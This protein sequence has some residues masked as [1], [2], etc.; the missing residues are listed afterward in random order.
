MAR[1]R[2][3]LF[4]AIRR[5]H[6]REGMS[7]RGLSDRYGV[8]RRTVR[9]A[10]ESPEPPARKAPV[11]AAPR[12]DPVKPLIDAMLRQ[13]LDA[14]RKQRHTARRVRARLCDEHGVEVSFDGARLRA[15]TAAAD[16]SGGGPNTRAGVRAADPR[17][18]RGDLMWKAT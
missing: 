16:L 7:I 14:P 3:E 17:A 13:D 2:V 18:G 8:H 9:Q 15:G 5:D 4:E 10:L 12:L 1:S 6:R 11:R